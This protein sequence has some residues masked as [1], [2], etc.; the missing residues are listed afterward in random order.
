MAVVNVTPDS[1]SDGGGP[2]WD[3]LQNN[4]PGAI[5][6]WLEG[7]LPNVNKP[8]YGAV[9]VDVGGQSTRPGA[10]EVSPEIELQRVIPFIK[11]LRAARLQQSGIALSISIDTYRAHVA[12]EAIAAGADIVNDIS[13]GA[14]DPDMLPTVA[15]LGRSIVLMHMRGTPA[16]MSSLTSYP[17]GI[18]P[19]VGQ[20]LL[21]RVRAAEAAGIRRWRI[22]LDPGIGFAKTQTQNLEIL[23]RFSELRATEGLEGIPWLVGTSRKGFIGRITGV[24]E[25]SERSWGTAAAVTAAVQGGADMVRVHDLK[26][27]QQV[28]AMAD[29]I[30][31]V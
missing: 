24:K 26:E 22:I 19:T 13:S 28:V 7:R 16:T 9:V 5:S 27:M 15:S 25:A 18:I 4:D 2:S 1:F 6:D 11:A 30:W 23:R 10:T 3:L 8:E 31:R 20:E 14:L 12:A 21:A 29:A 17:D